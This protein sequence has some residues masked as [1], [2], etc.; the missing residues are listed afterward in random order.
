MNHLVAY[1]KNKTIS[2]LGFNTSE[3]SAHTRSFGQPH[4]GLELDM[5]PLAAEVGLHLVITASMVVKHPPR[6]VSI[7]ALAV[8]NSAKK[9]K[10]YV[11]KKVNPEL[12]AKGLK[13]GIHCANLTPT[14]LVV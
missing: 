3:C 8:R 5:L 9:K 7:P 13:P 10:K 11:Q 4:G 6:K 14:F 2:H 12:R 1:I